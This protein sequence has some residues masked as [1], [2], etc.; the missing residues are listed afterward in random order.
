MAHN[1]VGK[2]VHKSHYGLNCGQ[3]KQG[4]HTATN[5]DDEVG[6]QHQP[7]GQ[8]LVSAAFLFLLFI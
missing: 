8:S 4:A 6:K 3:I 1:F 2:F 7:R 5:K